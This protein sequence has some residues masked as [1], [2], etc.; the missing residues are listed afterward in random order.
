MSREP[1]TPNVLPITEAPTP[2]SPGSPGLG[3][4]VIVRGDTA[5]ATP[6]A[7]TTVA[8]RIDPFRE[9]T[10]IRHVFRNEATETIECVYVGALPYGAAID[11]LVLRVG[12]KSWNGRV[13]RRAQAQATYTEARNQGRRTAL[14]ELDEDDIGT[15][16]VGTVRPGEEV[17]ITFVA[18]R[19]LALREGMV[20]VRLPLVLGTRF[21]VGAGPDA[22][23]PNALPRGLR[24]GTQ[25]R[26]SAQIVDLELA[27]VS[28]TQHA[29]LTRTTARETEITLS[30]QDEVPDRDFVLRFVPRTPVAGLRVQV[31]PRV[32]GEGRAVAA[33]LAL[34]LDLANGHPRRLPRD[35]VLLVD[36]S[37][38]M[39]GVKMSAACRASR[40]ALRALEAGDRFTVLAFD[41]VVEAPS[42]EGLAQAGLL[43]Y[44]QGAFD[45][46]DAFLATVAARGGTEIGNALTTALTVLGEPI[47]G[48]DRAIVLLTDGQVQG[49]DAILTSLG[50][51]PPPV[52][53]LGIDD[54]S[55]AG[56]LERIAERSGGEARWI[57]P[58]EDVEAAIEDL[59]ASLDVARLRHVML[60]AESPRQGR[61]ALG[62]LV[63]QRPSLRPG[64]AHVAFGFVPDDTQAL[65]LEGTRDDGSPFST[66]AGL[67]D[68]AAE[69]G[70]IGKLWAAATLARGRDAHYD[71]ERATA[72]AL[73]F[74]ILA[75]E[76]ALVLV[77]DQV[78]DHG[79]QLRVDVPVANPSGWDMARGMP[80]PAPMAA[81]CAKA[82]PLRAQSIAP[83]PA[84]EMQDLAEVAPRQP[85]APLR[86][87]AADV[88]RSEP[89]ADA[90]AQDPVR[91]LLAR[92]RA[93]GSFGDGSVR[94]TLNALKT[95]LA[96]PGTPTPR[97]AKAL[98]KARAF[99]LGAEAKAPKS[100]RAEL[101][102]LLA[103]LASVL[104]G[105]R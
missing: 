31:D 8:I 72:L 26:I 60:W 52:L 77:G 12:A 17:T 100:D 32:E 70:A 3:C 73:R 99:L 58:G 14:L 39:Q 5:V 66:R 19:P 30:R 57:G 28:C 23:Q 22:P 87:R 53:A 94:A 49:L 97:V 71:A 82:A 44:S 35:L 24:P 40:I 54:A 25:L 61:V 64:S 67:T 74:G 41:D 4:L 91:E 16:R 1:M 65:V 89:V 38:S 59:V 78:Q 47:E 50:D 45:R 95:L 20:E 96:G 2:P 37:G 76:V 101:T 93:D 62:G 29:T 21:R 104:D 36:R 75:R 10:E 9:R 86:K 105:S 48:R 102:T 84:A 80:A 55:N 46:A 18:V 88:A 81:S 27:E 56:A 90:S 51:T 103:R 43:P 6:L 34:P 13:E 11:S 7:S 63:G 15:L 69:A 42:A 68:V 92:Q 79:H 98:A 33:H 83:A 85:A